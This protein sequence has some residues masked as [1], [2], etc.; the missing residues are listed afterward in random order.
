[1]SMTSVADLTTA[2][3]AGQTA[4]RVLAKTFPAL[5]AG[6]GRAST[7]AQGTLPKA[8]TV[9][10]GA[11]TNDAA[12][13]WFPNVSPAKQYLYQLQVT[14][15]GGTDQQFLVLDRLVTVA[16][17]ALTST[18]AKTVNSASVASLPRY[19]DGVGVLP[20]LEVTTAGTTTAAVVHLSKYTDNDGNANQ[21]GGSFTFPQNNPSIGMVTAPL[22]LAAGD[23][24]V[25]SVEELTVDTAATSLVVA[26]VLARPLAR[27]YAPANSAGDYHTR[28]LLFAPTQLPRLYDGCAP[29]LVGR[30]TNLS[31]QNV[32]LLMRSVWA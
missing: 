25:Q 17:I 29:W 7:Y 19:T 26:V 2:L 10:S 31:N 20:F 6:Y 22:P 15:G 27:L 18:G 9:S 24:G 12:T 8:G 1:M 28:P 21:V 4:T 16:S 14:Q 30:G 23:R 13:P 3:A 5:N 11:H 32:Q